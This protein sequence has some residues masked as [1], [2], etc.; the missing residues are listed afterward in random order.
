M[1]QT[2][3]AEALPEQAKFLLQR[4][5]AAAKRLAQLIEDLLRYSR[6][7]RTAIVIEDF[8][9]THI[10]KEV[11]AELATARPGCKF[12]IQEGLN[13]TGDRILVRLLLQNLMDNACKFSPHGTVVQVGRKGQPFFVRDQGMGFDMAYADKI[14]LPFERL[15]NNDDVPG[16]GIGLA[17]VK[18]IVEKH[19]GSIW[20]NSN[21]GQGTTFFFTLS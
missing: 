15:V 12:E 13:A 5:I 1:L 6:L 8:D 10:A 14:F 2:D 11:A 16:T 21:L 17:N 4:Q 9:L 3:F 20:V 7:G 18:R 19:G